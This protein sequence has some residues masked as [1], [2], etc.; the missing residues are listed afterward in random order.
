VLTALR[1]STVLYAAPVGGSGMRDTPEY[2]WNVDE[3]IQ[4][5][6]AK[7]V[8]T[9]NE[10]FDESLPRPAAENAD[11]FWMACSEWKIIGRC[12][13]IGFDDSVQ[14]IRHY[15]WAI[16]LDAKYNK[17]VRDFWDTE[18]WTTTRYREK[19]QAER[20]RG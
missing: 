16:D 6:S 17:I 10:L 8:H 13:R 18:F 4:A 9:F 12:V 19:Q 5:R 2:V 15:H 11:K 1:E 20:R 7:F 3:I 14:P